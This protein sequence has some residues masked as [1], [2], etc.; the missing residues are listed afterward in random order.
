M[1]WTTRGLALVGATVI[2]WLAWSWVKLTIERRAAREASYRP[3]AATPPPPRRL[4]VVPQDTEWAYYTSDL[5]VP[6]SSA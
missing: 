4:R 2:G 6:R 1:K 5:D 3:A